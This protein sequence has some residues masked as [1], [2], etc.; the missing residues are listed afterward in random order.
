MF[1]RTSL[2]LLLALTGLLP[3]ARG[4]TWIPVTAGAAPGTP[5]EFVVLPASDGT[6][7]VL[8]VVIHG[9]WIDDVVGP[10]LVTYQTI[11]VP[12]LGR[13][14]QVGAPDLPAARAHLLVPALASVVVV[15]S[16]VPAGGLVLPAVT[17]WPWPAPALDEAIDPLESP[18]PG[19]PDGSDAVFVKDGAIYGGTTPFPFV[20]GFSSSLQD[21]F[22]SLPT[23]DLD[24]FPIQWDPVSDDLTVPNRVRY[25]VQHS[26]PTSV[27]PAMTRDRARL[28]EALYV[29]WSVVESFFPVDLAGAQRRWLVVAPLAYL[30]AVQELADH[31]S[32]MGFE[33][34]TLPVEA[35]DGSCDGIRALIDGWYQGGDPWADHYLLLVGD[36]DD[37]PLCQDA[38]SGLWGDALY[39]SPGDGDRHPELFGGRLSVDD[40]T[41][42]GRQID[43]II[44]YELNPTPG[45]AYD[46]A[47]LVAHQE[48]DYADTLADLAAASYA[49]P[50]STTLLDGGAGATD[51][52]VQGAINAGQG[53]V[54]YRGH[55]TA[56]AWADWNTGGQ[57]FHKNEVLT[58]ANGNTRPVVWSLGC[59]NADL[60]HASGTTTDSLGETWME[61][62][63]RGAVAHLGATAGT[64][65]VANDGLAGA[66]MNGL[67]DE[68][69]TVHGQLLAYAHQR[70]EDLLPNTNRLAY[71]LLGDA[72]MR[73]RRR[74][75]EPL[76]LGLP[77]ELEACQPGGAGDCTFVATVTDA[78]NNPLEGVLVAA[79]KPGSPTSGIPQLLITAYTDSSGVA[80]IPLGPLDIG[81]INVTGSDDDGNVAEGTIG[82][83]FE[84]W[85]SFGSALEGV[86]GPPMA[87]GMGDLQPGTEVTFQ[88]EQA[89]PNALA[90]AFLALDLPADNPGVPFKCGTLKV[91]PSTLIQPLFMTSGAGTLSVPVDPWPALPADTRVWI[92]WAIQDPAAECGVALSNALRATQP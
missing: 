25:T 50:P 30:P 62:T 38:N 78:F 73:V 60:A 79:Y 11:E 82:L 7:T 40:V 76:G 71:L 75:P 84:A 85:A 28:A 15:T 24:L 67:Y 35:S 20:S 4:Q 89:A 70:S 22:G 32:A 52:A 43:K 46:Q 34:T 72:A 44:G 5:A 77:L 37:I 29:N 92:Q 2:A 81:T 3:A 6:Q 49:V 66:L 69:L 55:G 61:A 42:L 47:L 45:G 53:L 56:H 26:G 18:G 86:N 87:A 58:L 10:D 74:A 68:D 17:P 88:L 27:A 91:F 1:R 12:G 16:A 36:H 8:D 39:A 57:D 14:G 19:D 64:G 21:R 54:L 51:A 41:D 65:R 90:G 13:V 48:G 59:N 83:N 23:A 63:F 33:V 31:R 9:L 80:V